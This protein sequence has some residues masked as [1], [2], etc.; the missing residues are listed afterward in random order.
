MDSPGVVD[1]S[2]LPLG[3]ETMIA[4]WAYEDDAISSSSK[5]SVMIAA[6]VTAAA[7]LKLF[8][9]LEMLGE[10]VIYFDTYY[11]CSYTRNVHPYH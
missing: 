5:A 1:N 11:I 10:R 6:Y 2:S 4:N 3:E 9:Y 7:R 8:F